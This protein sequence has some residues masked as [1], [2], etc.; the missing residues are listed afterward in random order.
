MPSDGQLPEIE[1]KALAQAEAY[2]CDD[3]VKD[4]LANLLSLQAHLAASEF[5]EKKTVLVRELTAKVRRR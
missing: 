5:S 1:P 3:E 2:R 4:V